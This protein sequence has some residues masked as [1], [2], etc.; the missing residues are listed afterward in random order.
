MISSVSPAGEAGTPAQLRIVFRDDLIPLEQL[1]SPGERAILAHFSIDPAFAGRFRFLTPR[2][3]G[4]DAERAWPAATRVRVTVSK[5]LRDARGRSLDTDVAWTFSTP[6]LAIGDLPGKDDADARYDLVPKIRFDANVALERASLEA[7]AYVVPSDA[8]R[9]DGRDRIAL[10]IP[11]DTATSSAS[12][13]PTATPAPSEAF[14]PSQ[15]DYRYVLV[16]VRPLAKA[17]TYAVVIE[18][19]VLPR[20]GNLPSDAPFKGTFTT[21]DDLRFLGVTTTV[22]NGPRRFARGDPTLT[23]TTPI[24]QKSIGALA[25]S[26]RPP[27]GA[28]AFAVGY[29]GVVGVNAALLAPN[30]TYAVSIGPTLRDT[31]G[32]TLAAPQHAAFRTGDLAPDVWA[33]SGDDLFP[34]NREVR[35]NVVAVNAPADVTAIFRTLHPPDVVEWPDPAG[36]PDRGDVLPPELSWPRFDARGPRNVERTIEVPLRAKLVA[37]AGALAYGVHAPILPDQPFSATGIVQLTDLGAFAQLFPDAARVAV[38]RISDGTPVAGAHVEIYPSQADAE[39]KTAPV[40]CAGGTTGADGLATLAGPGFAACARRDGGRNES[41]AFVTIVRLGE[42]WTYVRTDAYSGAYGTFFNGWSSATPISRGTI[43]SDRELYQPGETAQLTAVGWFLIDGTLE[44]GLAPSYALTL[45][46]PDGR[47]RDLGRRA[48]DAFGMTSLPVSIGRDDPLGTYVVRASAGDG[49]AL[50]GDFRVAEFKPPNFKV[51]LRLDRAVALPGTSVAANATSAYLFGAP[52]AGTPTHYTVTRSS[53]DFAPPGYDGYTFGRHWFWPDQ[54][55]DA[56]TD[57]LDTTATNRSDGTSSVAVPVP[58]ASALPY[59]MTYEVD[60]ETTDASNVA[61]SDSK[62]FTALPSGT[63]VGVKADDVGTA[64]SPLGVDAIATDPD[65]RARPGTS[66][67]VELQAAVYASA[68]QIVEGAEQPV[69][70]VT[71]RTVTSAGASTAAKPVHL[72]LIPPK[73]GEYRVR[74]S[75]AGDAATETDADVYVGG[76]GETAWYAEDPNALT[77]KLDKSSYAPGQTVTALVQS[78]FPDAEIRLSVVRHGVLWE[79]T[80]RTRGSAPTFHFTVTPAM[81]PNAV[82]EAFVVRRGA[83][84]THA[85]GAAN[86]LARVGFAPFDVALGGKYVTASVR[87]RAATL[88]PGARQTVHVHLADAAQRAVRGELTLIVANDSVLQLTGYRPPDLVKTVYAGQPISTRYAD[89]RS[90]LVLETPQR[91]EEKGW[92]FGGGLSGEE[93]DPRVRRK[94]QPL[95]YFA[96][97]LHTDANGDAGVSFTLPDDLTTWRV[98]AVAATADGRFGNGETTFRTTQPLIANPVMPQ[99]ARPGDAFDGG[100][101]VTNG[102]GASGTLRVDATLT[103]PLSFERD[104]VAV[105]ATRFD[106]PLERITR[107][108]RFPVVAHAAGVSTATVRVRAAG[109]GDAFAIP[110]PVRDLDVLEAVAQTG[111]TEGRASVGLNVAP[112]TP[113]DAGGLDIDLASSPIPEIVV[114]AQAALRGDERLAF[115]AASRLAIAADLVR[116]G[117]RAGADTTALRA[118]AASEIANLRALRRADGGFASYW[119]ADASDPWDSLPALGAL[120]RARDANAGDAALLDGARAYAA[121]VLADPAHAARWCTS[122]ECKAQLRLEALDALAAAGDARTTFLGELDAQRDRLSFADR[123]RLARLESAAPAYAGRAA[124]LAASLE[125]ALAVTARGAAVNLPAR[126]AWRD[127]PVV[128]Q[129]EALRLELAR[130][131][132]PDALDRIARALLDMRR[133][134]SFGCACENA[135][136]LDALVDLAA[137]EPPADFSAIATLDGRTIARARFV[138]ARAPQRSA[139]VAMRALPSGA[140]TVALAK[141]GAGTLHYAVTYRYRLGPGAPGR[142]NG[143][144]VTRVVRLANAPEVLATLGLSA[145]SEPLALQPARVYDVE[146]QIVADHPVDR[147]VI[148]D[149]LPAGLE[150]VDTSFATSAAEHAPSASWE[151]GDQQIRIDRIE[152]YADHLEPGIYRLHYLARSVTP[153]TFLWPGAEAHLAARPDEF[154]RTTATTVAIGASR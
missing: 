62:T 72:A 112:G 33:P 50:A 6:A 134:G 23:F 100:V 46:L 104:G 80:E 21:H 143:L 40:P 10:V 12:P 31:F 76:T 152:A 48:L 111:T 97:A 116:L 133:N 15:R 7:H 70:S 94:F 44:R 57:V 78:P 102:T 119:R 63:L 142:L 115:L 132:V 36:A 17:T 114:A 59:A 137:R 122:A 118:R 54:I 90:A 9:Q 145:R 25:L 105:A 38:N 49:E 73:P 83:P 69:E 68:T 131:A 148:T 64:G 13:Q 66:L 147:V 151:I 154:G 19:G 144:R 123:A 2:M 85:S 39:K 129:A 43:F 35:L 27:P 18:P 86:P 121:N 16:P 93:A 110:V 71:Y 52:L 14:D 96:A 127:D 101:A 79:T 75:V 4:F 47:K 28:T 58:V 41:P 24:D 146:L 81:L 56:S 61:V 8:P 99:F 89:N 34:A 124:S 136:A 45:E 3:I 77:V 109:T 5:G 107:A 67:H 125:S 1:E 128:A 53:A 130:G 106:V 113:L 126:Y 11:P 91:P 26:P 108:Y 42:D 84:P 140:S 87:A 74:A 82:V 138:G 149:P 139:T 120:A 29:D 88:A 153:G 30:T 51:D 22:V 65:G 37:D 55:P 20:D 32:Q 117:A 92:G 141:S 98:L 60:A 150:A 135:A 95:A 103:P